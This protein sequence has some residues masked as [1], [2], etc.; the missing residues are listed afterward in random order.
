MVLVAK[1]GDFVSSMAPDVC[2]SEEM[3]IFIER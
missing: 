1:K 2:P 3:V